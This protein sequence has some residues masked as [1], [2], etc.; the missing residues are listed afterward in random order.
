M[1]ITLLKQLE[2]VEPYEDT[3]PYPIGKKFLGTLLGDLPAWFLL[4]QMNWIIGIPIKTL[5][6]KRILKYCID[7]ESLLL[8]EKAEED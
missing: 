6:Q 5:E 4:A 3:D 1:N 2:G 7:N 8:D